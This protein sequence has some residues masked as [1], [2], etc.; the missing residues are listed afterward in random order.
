MH[1]NVGREDLC[2]F[3]AEFVELNWAAARECL[4]VED[5]RLW[6]ERRNRVGGE[7]G[8]G[9]DS[10]GVE[11]LDGQGERGPSGPRR[12]APYG[13]DSVEDE[14]GNGGLDDLLGLEREVSGSGGLGA[15]SQARPGDEVGE[16]EQED[17]VKCSGEGWECKGD[18]ESGN[19][20]RVVAGV[21]GVEVGDERAEAGGERVVVARC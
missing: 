8:D 4:R 13:L 2:V 3:Y 12:V 5:E 14:N 19:C 9:T 16:G 7:E 21:R 10:D 17:K 11:V 20:E 18:E 15:S 6:P 1:D